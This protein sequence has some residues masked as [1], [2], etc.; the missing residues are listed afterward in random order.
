MKKTL[1]TLLIILILFIAIFSICFV[2]KIT[3]VP[4]FEGEK[5]F[6]VEQ[7]ETFNQIS[8]N[9]KKQKIIKSEFYFDLYL[10]LKGMRSSI[11]AG[12]YKIKPQNII[13]LSKKLTRGEADNE[14][15]IKI[16][17]GWSLKDVADNLVKQNLIKNQNNFL[18]LTLVKNFKNK[19]SFLNS[20]NQNNNLSLEGFIFPDT[21]RIYKNAT[22]EEIILKTL[23]NF[24]NKFTSSFRTEIKAQG[25]NLY[26]VLI[27]AS[28]IEMEVMTDEDRHIVSDI[29]WKRLDDG[30]NLQ[31]DSSLKY[32]IGKKNSNAL[33]F[34]ELKIDSPYNTYKYKGLPPTPIANPG[35]SA[36]RAAIYPKKSDYWFYLSD[37]EGNTIFSKTGAEHEANV[38]KYLR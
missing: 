35:A 38:E 7:G 34:A 22:L 1:I 21:Y 10:Y 23:D 25:K 11:Q 31:V 13:D 14:I 19:Y 8:K 15:D 27:V 29:L 20:I 37:K 28:I 4:D 16:I 18:N 3:S 5:E 6:V 36:I 2:Y 32:I 17:E 12:T 26:D 9:L 30:M 24:D 33:T